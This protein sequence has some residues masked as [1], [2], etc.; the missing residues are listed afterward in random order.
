MIRKLVLAAVVTLLCFAALPGTGLAAGPHF[1][2]GS[3]GIGDSYFPGDGNG[4]YD[5]T[6]YDLKITYDPDSDNLTGVATISVKATQDLSAFN[7]DFLGMTLREL[8]VD[9]V[10]AKTTRDGQELTVT[11]KSGIKNGKTFTVVAKYDGVP[12]TLED[13]GLSGF[14]HTSDGAIAIGEP[15]VAA[16][17]FPANDHPRDKASF[18]IAVTIPAGLE[19]MSNG[20]LTSHKTKGNWTTWAWDEQAPMATYLA[21]IAVGQ[22]D[23]RSYAQDGIKYWDAIDSAFMGDQAPAI[24]PDDGAAFLYSQVGDWAYKRLTHVINVPAGGA[25]VSFRANRDTEQAWDHLF[26]EVHTVG[27]D[28]WTTLP[29]QNGHTSQDV[30]ACPG[31]PD[32]N[33]FVHHYLTEFVDEHDPNDPEDDEF[34]C[35]PTGTTGEWNAV[36]GS[37]DGWED[38]R[39]HV[40]DASGAPRQIELSVTYES[41]F[42]F[43]GRGVVLDSINVST[44]EG[45][46]SFEADGDTMDGWDAPI[47]RPDTVAGDENNPPN[48]NTWVVSNFVPPV[49]GLGDSA[50]VSL[51]RQPEILAFE[52]ANFGAYPFNASGGIVDDAF[53][54]FALENQ[55]RP[56][57]SPFFFG[58]PEGNDFVVVHELAHMWYRDSVSVN[59]WR[60]IWLNEGFATY[61][62]WLWSEREGFGTAQENFDGAYTI[63]AD[64]QF[65]EMSIGDPGPVQLFDFPVYLRGAMTLQ[66]L[67]NTVGDD[68]FFQILRDWAHQKAGGNGS[69][70]QFIALAET[71][72]G[73]D[74][75]DL[76]DVWLSAGKPAGYEPVETAGRR[77]S[78]STATSA[79]KMPAALR[80]LVERYSDKPGQPF[81]NLTG[82]M[83]AKL[84]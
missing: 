4:G 57:Y 67:R 79:Q 43:Q 27:S 1:T 35:H 38:W 3:P 39:V 9:N 56:T 2:A 49:P 18:T 45:T 6:H 74:L 12:E 70:A 10:K 13:F 40:P 82:K 48:P 23:V 50:L 32:S 42:S 19:G 34:G 69:Q 52:A 7:L 31:F 60:D 76:F 84:R 72:S 58:G 77:S 24:T 51:D 71:V 75:G 14:I 8:K 46:T 21:F 65:W 55:T 68:D 37:S 36:S 16:T 80:S 33:P 30:G 20:T 41:D 83:P 47:D 15:H 25:D 22:F 78:A 26:V 81:K 64:D 11:P 61:A 66:V 59:S 54:G 63:P 73:Q 53:V 28:D 62:E 17:W 44:G 5:V 29:D